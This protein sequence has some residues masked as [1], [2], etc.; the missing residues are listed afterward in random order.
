MRKVVTRKELVDRALTNAVNVLSAINAGIYFPTFSNGLKEVGRYLGCTWTEEN[1]SGLQSLVWRARWEQ[2]REPVWK[3]KLLTYNAEDC[4]SLKHVTEFVQAV[5]EAARSRGGV[6]AAPP[7]GPSVAWADQVGMVSNH[8]QFGGAR[9]NLPDFAHINRCAYFDYQREKVF[10]RT[11]KTVRRARLLQRRRRPRPPATRQID[12]GADACPFCGESRVTQL[13]E[14][15]C[16]KI[17]YD[18]K[19]TRGGIHRQVIR[20]KAAWHWCEDCQVRFAPEG[21]RRRDKH[22]HGLKSWA[23][24]QHVVHRVNISHLEGML[25]DFF[26]LCIDR[27]EL[28]GIRALMANRY[29]KT[30]DRILT[31]LVG[32][33]LV[34]ADETDVALRRGKGYVWVLASQE[35]VLYLY[36]PN[37]EAGFLRDLLAGFEGVLVSD[38]Y[39]GYDSL[40]CPQQKCL[41]HLI[42]DLNDDL[43]ANPFDDEFKALAGEFGRLLRSIV[44]T[45]DRHGLHRR[46]LQCHKAEVSHFFRDLQAR[47]YRSHTASAYQARFARTEGKLFTFLDH[48]NVPW[49]NNAAEHA[50]KAFAWYRLCADGKMG[51]D[52]LSDYLVLLSVQQTCKYRG[53]SFLKFL[54][55]QEEDVDTYCRLRRSKAPPPAL[56][57][58]PENFSRSR[59]K[60]GDTKPT[61][62]KAS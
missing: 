1:A 3:G 43:I 7:S 6:T 50:V 14:K 15:T 33:R 31:R 34:H 21:H 52:G 37:R 49:N 59:F 4:A 20:C 22:L 5:A 42:R 48:D 9:F 29:R 2:D 35:D 12:T 26:G 25:E 41:V 19:F 47:V 39:S 57:L 13:R 24:Y 23:M 32:G 16:S 54:L 27:T 44:D 18:L 62:D 11:N 10:L 61:A 56:E 51:E 55:S 40:D 38:F 36:R 46:H 58:Y 8:W 45:I 30:C 53:V 17:A 28:H 60:R